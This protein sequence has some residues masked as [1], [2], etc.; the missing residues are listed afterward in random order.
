MKHEHSCFAPFWRRLWT[1]C[2]PE[3]GLYIPVWRCQVVVCHQIVSMVTNYLLLWKDF[4][5]SLLQQ[6]TLNKY[7]LFV[8]FTDRLSW[9]GCGRILP[10]WAISLR[11]DVNF[12]KFLNFKI[13]LRFWCVQFGVGTN[14]WFRY[15]FVRPFSS[16][17]Y[18]WNCPLEILVWC[19]KIKHQNFKNLLKYSILILTSLFMLMF[20][21]KS[22][23]EIR[24]PTAKASAWCRI[25]WN[26]ARYLGIIVST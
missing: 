9:S 11:Q 17:L 7:I 2:D 21:M 4:L 24:I 8:H 19:S 25:K 14:P 1:S 6:L 18:A 13:C 22:T 3:Q 15:V 26:Y 10:C 5:K 16:F 20:T 23:K 12:V